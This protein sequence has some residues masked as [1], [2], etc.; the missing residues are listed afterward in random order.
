M[1]QSEVHRNCF[2]GT[3]YPHLQDTR[4]GGNRFIQNIGLYSNIHE[5]TSAKDSN[6]NIQCPL[7]SNTLNSRVSISKNHK[8]QNCINRKDPTSGA[9]PTRSKGIRVPGI[10]KMMSKI[11]FAT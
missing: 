11:I 8:C 9:I 4:D 1:L 6:F 3:Y 5:V 10:A 7:T 2:R